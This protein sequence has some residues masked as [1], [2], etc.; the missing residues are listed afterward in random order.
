MDLRETC[1]PTLDEKRAALL[2]LG[3]QGADYECWEWPRGRLPSGYG[4]FVV[5]RILQYAHRASHEVFIGPIPDGAQVCHRCDNPPCWNPAHLFAGT[6][7]VNARDRMEKGRSQ[8]GEGHYAAKLT[9]DDVRAIRASRLS[10]PDLA[11][12]Y[13]VKFSAI[14]KIKDGRSWKHVK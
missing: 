4:R 9:E 5:R 8:R 1:A 7:V 12:Q 6:A 13:G 14:Y 2:R 10:G 11:S 3:V